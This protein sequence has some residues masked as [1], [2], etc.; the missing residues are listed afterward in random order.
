M[1]T[2]VYN[3]NI[4]MMMNLLIAMW[5]QG[6]D[7]VNFYIVEENKLLLKATKFLP[8]PKEIEISKEQLTTITIED[9][10]K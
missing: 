4:Q 9:L 7:Y 5:S 8:P 2:V 1:E 6:A 3:V 10:A